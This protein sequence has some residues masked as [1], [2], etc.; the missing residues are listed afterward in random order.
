MRKL[1]EYHNCL[2][3]VLAKDHLAY[4]VDGPEDLKIHLDGSCLQ[5]NMSKYRCLLLPTHPGIYLMTIEYWY[6][7]GFMDGY[8]APGEREIDF[9]V[10]N[11]RRVRT[12]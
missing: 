11:I 3:A 8:P 4:L 12:Y 7:D 1:L 9:S 10:S 5:D 6:E 2:V